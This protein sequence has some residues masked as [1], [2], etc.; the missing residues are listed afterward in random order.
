MM[1]THYRTPSSPPTLSHDEILRRETN[2]KLSEEMV[3][4]AGTIRQLYAGCSNYSADQATQA[5]ERMA[6]ILKDR[7]V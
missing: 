1:N 6:K 7:D 5:Y 3:K 2:E 4:L